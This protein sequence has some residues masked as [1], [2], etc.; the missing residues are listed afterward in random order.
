MLIQ[1]E[2]ER[3]FWRRQSTESGGVGGVAGELIS[4]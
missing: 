2:E 1:V 4:F 3:K